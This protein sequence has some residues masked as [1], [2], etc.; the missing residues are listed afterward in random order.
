MDTN[1]EQ[2][3]FTIERHLRNMRLAVI[4][5]VAFFLYE[6]LMPAELRP[7]RRDIQDVVKTKELILVDRRGE[8]IARLFTPAK[9]QSQK[10]SAQLVLSDILGNQISLNPDAIQLY[11][12]EGVDTIEQLR[13]TPHDIVIYNEDGSQTT[14]H[15]Q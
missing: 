1:F 2:R 8:T 9:E 5:I 6:S 15:K 3:L 14:L 4:V 13:I 10:D 11:V 7:G 12:R